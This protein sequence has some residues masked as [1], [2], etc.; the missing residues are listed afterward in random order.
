MYWVY[1]LYSE[2]VR[3]VYIG[4]TKNLKNR[5]KEHQSGLV[6]STRNRRPL[7]LIHIEKYTNLSL[8]RKR[9]K[10]LKSLYGYRERKRILKE[11][12]GKNRALYRG[13]YT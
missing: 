7:V 11:Y 10:Y 3:N 12:L 5:I 9:E 2:K 13:P 6:K 1:F 4:C 8:A